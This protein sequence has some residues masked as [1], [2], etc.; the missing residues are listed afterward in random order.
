MLHGSNTAESVGNV[1]GDLLKRVG[2]PIEDGIPLDVALDLHAIISREMAE[3]A[4]ILID[5]AIY[6]HVDTFVRR[7]ETV[8]LICDL[9][10]RSVPPITVYALVPIVSTSQTQDTDLGAHREV[11]E[12]RTMPCND[13]HLR[14]IGISPEYFRATVVKSVSPWRAACGKLVNRATNADTPGI[15]T[16]SLG[17]LPFRTLSRPAFPLDAASVIALSEVELL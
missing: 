7:R 2:N 3:C 1:R 10:K 4:E 6:P 16:A 9:L 5:C 8:I 14:S 11:F 12:R 13:E 17:T 15:L